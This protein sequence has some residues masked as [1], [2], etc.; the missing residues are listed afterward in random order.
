MT[1]RFV[2]AA[3][4]VLAI[5]AA[6]VALAAGGNLS[7]ALPL[8][9]V[10]TVSA[11]AVAGL[12]LLDR[13]ERRPPAPELAELPPSVAI[14]DGLV[15]GSFA[16]QTVLND[17]RFLERRF[18][19]PLP[20]LTPEEEARVLALPRKEYLAWIASRVDLLEART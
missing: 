1:G 6:F 12:A 2:Y 16:R 3:L 20:P 19:V 4:I 7:L 14:L 11:A 17:L 15:G 5:G 18:D 10:A 8:A 13:L 9:L